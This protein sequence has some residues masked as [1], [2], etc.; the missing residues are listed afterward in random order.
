MKKSLLLIFLMGVAGAISAQVSFS[1]FGTPANRDFTGYT[2]IGFSPAPAA[3]ELDS[4]EWALT[5]FSDGALA[6]GGTQNT[7][8]TDFTRGTTTPGTPTSGGLYALDNAGNTALWVQPTTTDFTPGTLTLR[9][10]NN[11]GSVMNTL[12]VSF[13]G[14]SFNNGGFRMSLN[15]SYS[16]DDA[17]YTAVPAAAYASVAPPVAPALEVASRGAT[18]ANLNLPDGGFLYLRWTF[19]EVPG[20]T[21]TRDEIGLDNISLTPSNAVVGTAGFTTAS[22][23]ASENV[24]VVTIDVN[25]NPAVN[26]TVDVVQSGGTATTGIDYLFSS[27]QTVTLSAGSPTFSVNLLVNDDPQIELNETVIFTL[28]NP[29]AGCL[30]GPNNQY[31]L[32]LTDNDAQ[33][34]AGVVITEIMYNSPEAGTDS[35][36]FIELFNPTASSIDLSACAFTSG[37]VYTFPSGTTIGAGQYLVLAGNAVAFANVYGF[38]PFADWGAGALSN[39]G[40]TLTL[41]DALGNIIDQ[42][43]FD[44]V[45]PWVTAPDGFGPSLTLCSPSADNALASNW[46]S[47]ATATGDTINLLPLLGTP[48]ANDPLVTCPV[49]PVLSFAA[50]T[51]TVSETA[52]S[53]TVSVSLTNPDTDTT[54]VNVSLFA[55]GSTAVD[56]QDFNFTP[57]TLVFPPNVAGAQTF[58]L[59]LVN[60]I[61]FEN[62]ETIVL[63]LNNPT[64]SAVLDIDT[65]TIT[66]TSEDVTSSPVVGFVGSAV[67]VDENVG[68]VALQLSL[69]NP[70]N[71]ATSVDVV[72]SG[73]TATNGQDFNYATTTVT[74]PANTTGPLSVSLPIVDDAQTELSETVVLQLSN[75][76]NNA[77]LVNDLFTVTL[78]PSDFAG[79]Q[80]MVITEIFYDMPGAG[81]DS[82]EFVELYN[83]TPFPIDLNG[84][85]FTLG[86]A[87]TFTTTTVVQPG[88]YLTLARFAPFFAG[89]F[90]FTPIQW[91]TGALTNTG[92]PIVLRDAQGNVVDSVDF[93]PGG[94]WP[95]GTAGTGA[96]IVLCDANSDNALGA[97][98]RASLPGTGV[99][100]NGAEIKATPN[101]ADNLTC[102]PA[103]AVQ[104]VSAAYSVN[105]AAGQ[106]TVELQLSLAYPT[107]L[108]CSVVLGAGG[109]ATDG[110]D[111]TYTSPQT[112]IFPA[113]SVAPV[114]VT[115]SITDDAA[116]EGDETILLFLENPTAPANLGGL[117][118]ATVTIVDN[119]APL[120]PLLSFA[121]TGATFDESAG[122]VSVTVN[123][124]A[125]N[126]NATSV[127]VVLSGGTATPGQDFV[128]ATQTLTFPAGTNTPQ[129]ATITLTDD[130]TTEMSETVGLSLANATNG[131]TF[132]VDTY[133]LTITDNDISPSLVLVGIY[134][135]PL[136]GGLPK[137]V[138]L[139]ATDYIADLSRYGISSATNGAGV[140]A[141]QE[142]TFP[143]ASANAGE[144]IFVSAD[145]AQFANFFGFAP[146][147]VTTSNAI[148]NNGDDGVILYFN[149]APLDFFGDP[150]VDG[151][152]TA[153]EYLDGWAYRLSG[154]GPDTAFNIANWT[155][156]G[157]NVF[158][159]QTTNA[160]TPTPYPNCSYSSTIIPNLNFAVANTGVLEN[161]AGGQYLVDIALNNPTNTATT[162]EVVLD[163]ASTATNGTDFVFTPFTLTFPAGTATTLQ[164]PIDLVNDALVEGP[165]T[166]VLRLTNQNNNANIGI[167]TFTL[168]ILDDDSAP[169]G[170]LVITEINYNDPTGPDSLEFIELYNNSGGPITLDGITFSAGITFSFPFNNISLAAGQYVVVARFPGLLQAV[171]GFLPIYQWLPSSL[172]NATEP[173]VLRDANGNLIDSVTYADL[174]P[175]PTAPDGT[176]A[177]LVLCD[178]S[179]DNTQASNWYASTSPSGSVNTV[180]GPVQL[181]V[182]PGAQDNFCITGV[183]GTEAFEVALYPN[184][185]DG[186]L[187]VALPSATETICEL[188]NISGQVV[189]MERLNA[190]FS[191][192]QLGG[193]PQGMYFA[194]LTNAQNGQTVVRK[195]VL[196]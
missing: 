94:L 30:I 75:P 163:P 173:I 24:G 190:Q 116:T 69:T 192:I 152:G 164:V 108:Q 147:F 182:S 142:W 139:Y 5:G 18:L 39:N 107:P 9:C 165:E 193:L 168:T 28:T 76:T 115:F 63:F 106:A 7:P 134:D 68:T 125:P 98:W 88:E 96:S 15:L 180:N 119:E 19:A 170:G 181:F 114:Q 44:D 196:K 145:S 43:P 60:D 41:L 86:F 130:A 29:S 179:S 77:V 183:T 81:N 169:V 59:S 46:F 4:D 144:C 6:F 89:V 84:S 67:T 111:F 8:G 120:N 135:A 22:A 127:D 37:I 121:Q 72:L 47:A 13:E 65:L 26:C 21:G 138:E 25:V 99:L 154:S 82:L 104:F 12:E 61:Q 90:G 92:E 172:N 195:V 171:T 40:A 188:L 42:V 162:V 129:T 80:G 57:T 175:W 64:N 23:T 33:A 166:V 101:S 3:G 102:A 50:A 185:T 97:N 131:A 123:L 110:T 100:I 118:T 49:I 34:V 133:T 156:S 124:I 117:D 14:L 27:P 95:T 122:T 32:T 140:P 55:A 74:F 73:G 51:A 31:T 178:Y 158:D 194:R 150:N 54:R 58:S 161:L 184:P 35:L 11:T 136:A 137:G 87:H 126:A 53:Y 159:N 187:H 1:A 45:A 109:T 83:N 186:L 141:V 155:F 79:A 177:S 113:N 17:T 10:Q 71:N 93:R 91:N 85:V 176:G 132:N 103:P 191:T 112:V 16:L 2:G 20:G 78:N 148:S 128:F 157:I 189:R 174:A 146:T 62:D 66:L 70:S 153:W 48:G 36:E 105:E 38:A 149:G 56:G 52:G 167:G 160:T 143:A 151:T